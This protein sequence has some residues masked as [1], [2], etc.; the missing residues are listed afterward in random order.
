MKREIREVKDGLLQITFPDE[1]WYARK[2]LDGTQWQFVPS[3][4]WISDFYPKGVGFYKWLADHGWD[5]AEAIKAAAGDK[6]SKVHQGIGMLLAGRTVGMEDV[7]ENPRTLEQE[8]ITP[9]EYLALM[10]FVDWFN[11][12]KPEV[13]AF[14]YTVWNER[15]FYAGTVDLKCRLNHEKFKGVYIIDFKTSLDIWP[16]MEMQVSAYR[17]A[18]LSDP[19][20]TKQAILQVGYRRNKTKKWKFT[21]VPDKFPLF[22]HARAIWKNETDGIVPLQREYPLSLS[23]SGVNQ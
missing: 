15:Y 5:E 10:S 22:L 13:I 19:R 20:P 7:F 17:K 4:T 14:D 18:D 6:G 1:R 16:S 21:E 2:I 8:P 23:L 12:F 9:D 11:E 3:V